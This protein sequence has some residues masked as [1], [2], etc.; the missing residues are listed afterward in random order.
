GRVGLRERDMFEVDGKGWRLRRGPRQAVGALGVVEG[1][2]QG[3]GGHE[4]GPLQELTA[5]EMTTVRHASPGWQN[6]CETGEVDGVHDLGGIEGFG[7]VDAP[8]T[9]PV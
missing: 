7:P 9:E 3:A 5:G 1:R 8:P 2:Q 4:R 6:P